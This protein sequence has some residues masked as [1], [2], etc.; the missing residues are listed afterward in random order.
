MFNGRSRHLDLRRHQKDDRVSLEYN[1]TDLGVNRFLISNEILL[2]AG[3]LKSVR[4][5]GIGWLL[6]SIFV[7]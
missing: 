5:N 3:K 4:R 6:K 1:R 2:R 7:R